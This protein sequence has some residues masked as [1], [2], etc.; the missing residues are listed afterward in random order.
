MKF[1]GIFTEEK[2]NAH[3]K[4]LED[5]SGSQLML[6][7]GGHN[8]DFSGA[9]LSYSV[10]SSTSLTYCNFD[11]TKSIGINFTD[12]NL[13]GSTFNKADMKLSYLNNANMKSTQMNNAD[14]SGSDMNNVNLVG[15][16][17]ENSKL[18]DTLITNVRGNGEEVCSMDID[19]QLITFTK[20]IL[21][22][23]NYQ[24]NISQWEL[25]LADNPM[26]LKEDDLLEFWHKWENIIF[27]LIKT[28]YE[29]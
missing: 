1:N 25:M 20:D 12:T 28:K 5:R 19:R 7:G 4:W 18:V 24:H 27:D 9:N 16:K 22:I 6:S 2:Y 29:R 11:D 15:V 8:F 26:F 21:A 14:L 13:C 23:G 10:M 17:M 3:L